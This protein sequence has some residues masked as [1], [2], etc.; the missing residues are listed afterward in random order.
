[1]M[2]VFDDKIRDILKKN[3]GWI[4]L[5]VM[6]MLSVGIF[7]GVARVQRYAVV[8]DLTSFK[9]AEFIQITAVSFTFVFAIT[10]LFQLRE[11]KRL[12]IFNVILA[13]LV[14]GLIILGKISLLDY[15]SNDYEIFL[16]EWIYSY[17]QLPLWNAIGTYIGSDYSPPYLYFLA[18]ISRLTVFPWLYLIKAFSVAFD[19]LLAYAIMKMV[20]FRWESP[21]FRIGT[22]LITLLLP[23]V[24]FNGAYWGQ[25]D[26]IYTSLCMLAIYLALR[27][28][29]IGSFFLFGI[30]LSFKL[31]TVFFLPV[32]LPLWLHRDI[33][34]RWIFLIPAGYMLMM[35]PA[36]LA[37][38]SLHHVLTVFAQQAGQYNYIV[39][40]GPSIYELLLLSKQVNAGQLYEMLSPM[41]MFLTF[42]GVL[43]ISLML[44]IY[45]RRLNVET[46]LL[47]ALLY[48]S[49]VPLLLPKMHERYSFGADVM[50]MAVCM[51]NPKRRF[52]L[53]FFFGL[54]SYF[55]YTAGMAG[56]E[57]LAP[58]LAVLFY[59]AGIGM[60]LIE[61]VTVLRESSEAESSVL[62]AV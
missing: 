56:R 10:V 37:G 39:M 8:E 13:L 41:A 30:A 62:A 2:E 24:V 29:S 7:F 33:K 46:I 19:A 47:S 36:L 11:M 35:V 20:G 59:V 25:C 58:Q 52:A 1:M 6:A 17:T 53:P 32:L 44:C 4:T 28:K 51:W 48:L 34:L 49:A 12:S 3:V 14:T 26:I 43:G 40:N 54:S 38:K 55:L 50:A 60:T 61:L 15:Q 42:G 22:Y 21:V 27:Q 23:T 45:R 9:Q 16:S 5:A 18:L 57:V 31:Q